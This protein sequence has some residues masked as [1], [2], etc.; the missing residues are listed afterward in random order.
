MN[1]N[2]TK[3]ARTLMLSTVSLGTGMILLH[4]TG[5]MAQTTFHG[6][7]NILSSA[8]LS[9]GALGMI[10]TCFRLTA[11]PVQALGASLAPLPASSD[12]Q[13]REAA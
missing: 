5:A 4:I 1:R 11:A 9:L 8:L 6:A 7:L 12:Q 3:I 10:L 2:P 13:V